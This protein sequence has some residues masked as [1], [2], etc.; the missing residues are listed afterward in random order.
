M[1]ILRAIIAIMLVMSLTVDVHAVDRRRKVVT[2]CQEMRGLNKISSL[3]LWYEGDSVA[4]DGLG[5]VSEF[6]DLS[7]SK[8]NAIQTNASF[9]PQWLPEIGGPGP[10]FTDLIYFDGTDDFLSFSLIPNLGTSF[11]VAWTSEF[12]DFT[13]NRPILGNTAGAFNSI[14]HTS[15]TTTGIIYNNGLSFTFTHADISDGLPHHFILT[16]DGDLYVDGA[17]ASRAGIQGTGLS[18]DRIG[19]TGAVTYFMGV[20]DDVSVFNQPLSKSDKNFVGNFLET[21]NGGTWTD[22]P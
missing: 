16:S 1:R 10:D 15:S 18:F 4:V 3:V 9:R 5:G 7:R 21:R 14:N 2:G 13:F 12:V 6:R 19:A 11:T 20:L 8:N 17:A 22:I